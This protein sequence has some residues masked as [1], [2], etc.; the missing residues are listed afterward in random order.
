M[1]PDGHLGADPSTW[2]PWSDAFVAR[3]HELNWQ[4]RR[5]IA[6]YWPAI[7]FDW[8]LSGLEDKRQRPIKS[9]DL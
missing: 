9:E 2:S 1:F 5:T 6:V 7:Q 4:Q 3:L 8:S